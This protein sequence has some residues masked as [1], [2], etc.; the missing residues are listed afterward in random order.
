MFPVTDNWLKH[1]FYYLWGGGGGEWILCDLEQILQF[2]KHKIS[3]L[4]G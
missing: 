3:I 4:E 2:T 1:N